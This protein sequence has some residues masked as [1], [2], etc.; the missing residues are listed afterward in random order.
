MKV[1]I[2]KR[3]SVVKLDNAYLNS[4]RD[5]NTCY[6]EFENEDWKENIDDL[7]QKR[8]LVLQNFL[9]NRD[10]IVFSKKIDGGI[11]AIALSKD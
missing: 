9:N 3:L 6:P 7:L 2:K 4:N 1:H 5:Y 10:F 11:Y 8:P